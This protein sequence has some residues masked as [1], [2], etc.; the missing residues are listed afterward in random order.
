[1]FDTI[2]TLPLSSDLFA[3]ALHPSLPV[4]VAGLSSGHV[5]AYRLPPAPISTDTSDSD[6]KEDD[7]GVVQLPGSRPRRLSS[8]ASENGLGEVE[9]AWRTRRH[10]KGSCRGLGFSP[11]GEI[12]YSAGTDGL[13]KG[14]FTETGRV[15][16]KVAI[17]EHNGYRYSPS[18]CAVGMTPLILNQPSRRPYIGSCIDTSDA[19]PGDRFLCLTYLRPTGQLDIHPIEAFTNPSP[20]RRLHCFHLAYSRL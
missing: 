4:L 9:T 10:P 19:P 8:A 20:S 18:E 17:P 7:A 12:L 14:A 2:C 16:S 13:L 5:Q 6:E 15:C 1:M 11:D 3:Q